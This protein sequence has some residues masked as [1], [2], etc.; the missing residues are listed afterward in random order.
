[1]E[2]THTS[3]FNLITVFAKPSPKVATKGITTTDCETKYHHDYYCDAEK[4]FF[5][6]Q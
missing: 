1:M 6:I 4:P 5:A 2:T 3:I